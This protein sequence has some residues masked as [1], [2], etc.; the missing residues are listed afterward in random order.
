MIGGSHQVR[1]VTWRNVFSDL[2]TTE[3]QL[4]RPNKD[5]YRLDRMLER[6]AKQ[7]VKIYIIL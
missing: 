4:R 6:K 1:L 3:L 7:G 2:P 5:R